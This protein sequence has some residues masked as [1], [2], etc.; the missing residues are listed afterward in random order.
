MLAA[1]SSLILL[2]SSIASATAGALVLTECVDLVVTMPGVV[3]GLGDGHDWVFQI[4]L[5][6][7]SF[8][9]LSL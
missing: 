2:L 4:H 6:L 9:Y 5:P 7:Q 1:G 8:Q 3:L